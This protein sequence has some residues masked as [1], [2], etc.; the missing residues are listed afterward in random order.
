MKL[1]F[2]ISFLCLSFLCIAG[3]EG[4]SVNEQRVAVLNALYYQTF[5][6]N[7]IRIAKNSYSYE[8]S[9]KDWDTLSLS[10]IESIQAHS[11]YGDEDSLRKAFTFTDEDIQTFNNQLNEKPEAFWPRWGWDTPNFI[12]REDYPDYFS[13]EAQ[14]PPVE[15]PASKRIRIISLSV[16]LVSSNRAF[17][18]AE[19]NKGYG[20]VAVDV[21]LLGK[22]DGK[23]VV[24]AV[25]NV[26]TT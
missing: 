6:D 15:R 4:T 16:P 13:G 21:Y 18:A 7:S 23:W 22:K 8:S 20:S 17:V 12:S 2:F 9:L 5:E 14:L 26:F 19:T 24:I 10:E 3:C 1:Y 25:N 11:L